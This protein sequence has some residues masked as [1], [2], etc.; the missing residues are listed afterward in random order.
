MVGVGNAAE[1][2]KGSSPA[3]RS[4][5]ARVQGLKLRSYAAQLAQ[6]INYAAQLR[7]PC[8]WKAKPVA[9][10]AWSSKIFGS[11]GKR[12]R[13]LM[14]ML[15]EMWNENV[16][17]DVKTRLGVFEFVQRKAEVTFFLSC[18]YFGDLSEPAVVIKKWVC[19]VSLFLI[20]FITAVA[21]QMLGLW[22]RWAFEAGQLLMS[23]E[24]CTR[25][26]PPANLPSQGWAGSGSS[27]TWVRIPQF[28]SGKTS[29]NFARSCDW[30]W[31]TVTGG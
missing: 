27:E 28:Y 15:P 29:F 5:P 10:D 20:N 11:V 14:K 16:F 25:Q 24:Q 22:C 19:K 21:Q 7:K 3:Q 18:D 4:I 1:L 2:L 9:G 31:Y 23:S 26:H 12:C 6:F 30:G 8:P 13:W 17:G